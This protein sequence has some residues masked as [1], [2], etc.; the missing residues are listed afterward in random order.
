MGLPQLTGREVTVR[1]LR[2]SDARSLQTLLNAEEVNRLIAPFPATVEAWERLI[3]WMHAQRAEGSYVCFGVVPEGTEDAVGL[4]QVR[5]LEPGFGT[6]DW[7]FALGFPFWG[8]GVFHQAARLVADFLFD[9]V[10]T[11]RL[12]A[13]T[14]V[15][16]HR[17]IGALKKLGATQEGVL[18]KSLLRGGQYLDQILWTILEDDWHQARTRAAHRV[19]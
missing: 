19:H 14:A 10:G 6:A 18:R 4:V 11:H 13:R 1:E 17:A 15:A 7:D 3:V 2:A 8:S 12:E 16:N 5:Q 9:V